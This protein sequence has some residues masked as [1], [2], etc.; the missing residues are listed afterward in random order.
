MSALLE[1]DAATE[2]DGH[3]AGHE[4]L[5]RK[6]Y[7]FSEET[8]F[9]ELGG[10]IDGEPVRKFVVAATV[11]N[12]YA[13]SIGDSLEAAIDPSEALGL[14]FGERLLAASRGFE[15]QSY[16]KAC[17]VGTAGEYEHGNALLTSRFADPIR[18]AIGGGKAW[19]P[20]TGKRGSSGVT[21]DVPLAH[22]D[23]LYVRSHY[24]TMT[25]SFGD[26]PAP[27]ESVVIFAVA[28]RGRP[29]ARV[30]GLSASEISGEDG[31]T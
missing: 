17:I 10:E 13:N 14:A 25:V 2:N 31:L 5:I 18:D 6:W 9:S 19:V 27:D 23:A 11:R 20:S 30:G 4:L 12:P 28:T 3:V 24:D 26:A 16:G 1:N 22:K 7:C 15:I 29:N 21:I 8:Y